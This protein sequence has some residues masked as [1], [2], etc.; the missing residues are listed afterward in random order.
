ME[1]YVP[2]SPH[3][4][5]IIKSS[6][7]ELAEGMQAKYT[8]SAMGIVWSNLIFNMIEVMESVG[9]ADRGNVLSEYKKAFYEV[10]ADKG[11]SKKTAQNKISI[12]NNVNKLRMAGFDVKALISNSTSEASLIDEIKIA[13]EICGLNDG[14]NAPR[15][16]GSRWLSSQIIP[17]SN[18][19]VLTDEGDFSL[20]SEANEELLAGT[21]VHAIHLVSMLVKSLDEDDSSRAFGEII[22][23]IKDRIP[24]IKRALNE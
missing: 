6:A 13:L 18:S 4:R 20:W 14:R 23:K 1:K 22:E 2:L 7:Q 24:P 9:S 3:Q 11:L 17:Q 5:Q 10:C 21:Y 12:L 15:D 16:N 19:N 8:G